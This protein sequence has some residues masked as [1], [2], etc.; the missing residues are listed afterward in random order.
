MSPKYGVDGAKNIIINKHVI[1]ETRRKKKKLM[2]FY[3]ELNVL[4]S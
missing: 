4:T 1:N 2:M 3:I